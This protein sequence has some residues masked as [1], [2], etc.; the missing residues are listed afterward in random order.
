MQGDNTTTTG[1]PRSTRPGGSG[2]QGRAGIRRSRRMGL[3][4]VDRLGTGLERSRVGRR[5]EDEHQGDQGSGEVGEFLGCSRSRRSARARGSVGR[6][7]N[8][9]QTSV[10]ARSV[11]GRRPRNPARRI[12]PKASRKPRTSLAV[13]IQRSRT[14]PGLWRAGSFRTCRETRTGRLRGFADA[15][16]TPD[17]QE[18]QIDRESGGGAGGT[19]GRWAHSAG[20]VTVAVGCGKCRPGVRVRALAFSRGNAESG[21]TGYS[22]DGA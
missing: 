2:P 8:R 5:S 19:M 6:K 9:L 21:E 20:S 11:A 10:H 12:A 3:G 1:R 4:T 14:D 13:R 7:T 16:E 22:A 15:G 18:E 17:H